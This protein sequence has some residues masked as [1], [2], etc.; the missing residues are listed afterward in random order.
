MSNEE[1]KQVVGEAVAA[2]LKPV[3]KRL[4]QLEDRVASAYK[5][6]NVA[7][8]TAAFCLVAASFSVGY[9][10][11]SR[12]QL[13]DQLDTNAQSLC[14]SARQTAL[15]F[16][17]PMEDSRTGR[18]ESRRHYL[19]RLV[20]QRETLRAAAGLEC[21]SLKGFATF[22]YLRGKALVEIEGILYR[23]APRRFGPP[24]RG[25]RR[26]R[27]RE[28]PVLAT[29]TGSGKE[30]TSTH[31]DP[32]KTGGGAPPAGDQGSNNSGGTSKPHGRPP[33]SSPAPS[34]A[35]APQ[36]A[37]TS[38]A[39]PETSSP[40]SSEGNGNSEDSKANPIAEG[41]GSAVKGVGEVVQETGESVNGVV[42]GVAGK[43]CGLV[44]ASC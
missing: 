22:P 19:E 40:G 29:V 41:A 24:S 25:V 44:G 36:A 34:S 8:V 42:D 10:V 13:N 20:G 38:T 30:A 28:V 14:S 39:Q 16:R 23:L 1:L 21:P 7:L 5:I 12:T 33:K 9:A 26:G 15:A 18:K 27:Q 17:A 35:P 3:E 37:P 11:N 6:R 43:A 31:G 4:G 32:A 2:A